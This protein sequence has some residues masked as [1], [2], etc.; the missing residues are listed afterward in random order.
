MRFRIFQKDYD[1]QVLLMSKPGL[2]YVKMFLYAIKVEIFQ[3]VSEYFSKSGIFSIFL[4]KVFDK[5]LII[6]SVAPLAFSKCCFDT[7]P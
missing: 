2:V 5:L 3:S 6:V 1:H 4:A 7:R